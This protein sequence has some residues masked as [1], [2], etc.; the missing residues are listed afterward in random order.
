MAQLTPQDKAR[1]QPQLN[2]EHSGWRWFK[3]SELLSSPA[4]QNAAAAAVLHPVVELA[5]RT[6]PHREVVLAAVGGGSQ[7]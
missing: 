6:K 4:A 3:L 5:L 7:P 2:E 1:W